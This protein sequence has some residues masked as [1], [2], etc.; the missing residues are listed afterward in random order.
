M[1]LPHCGSPITCRLLIGE[2]ARLDCRFSFLR[3]SFFADIQ[4]KNLIHEIARLREFIREAQE[5]T[6]YETYLDHEELIERVESLGVLGA[7]LI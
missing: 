4:E 7:K 6:S 2:L 5:R 3:R 1:T